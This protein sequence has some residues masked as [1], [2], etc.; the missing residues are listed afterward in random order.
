MTNWYVFGVALGI[1]V[2][3][4]DRIK[5]ENSDVEEQKIKMFQFWLQYNVGASWKIVIQTLEQI[6]YLTLASR[7]SRK[8][9]SDSSTTSEYSLDLRILKPIL[10]RI[11]FSLLCRWTNQY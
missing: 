4:L 5:K 10:L 2:S 7:L 1:P 6:N 3:E 8:Y 11:S 9:L